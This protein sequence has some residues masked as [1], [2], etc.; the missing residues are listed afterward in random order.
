MVDNYFDKFCGSWLL[1]DNFAAYS[2]ARNAPCVYY[3]VGEIAHVYHGHAVQSQ[4]T[5]TCITVRCIVWNVLL[6]VTQSS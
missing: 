2:S 6:S 4:A 3:C 1:K 5:C